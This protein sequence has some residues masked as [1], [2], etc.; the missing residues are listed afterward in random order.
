MY[1]EY[2]NDNNVEHNHIQL[3]LYDKTI[4]IRN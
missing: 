1:D 3:A 2:T 4:I